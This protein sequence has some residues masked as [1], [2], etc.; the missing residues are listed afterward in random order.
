[1]REGEKRP[2]KQITSPKTMAIKQGSRRVNSERRKQ[3][4]N[5]SS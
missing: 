5:Q 4:E 3:R 1:M 2:S